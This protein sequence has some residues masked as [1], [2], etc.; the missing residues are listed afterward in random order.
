MLGSLVS[1]VCDVFRCFDLRRSIAAY[2]RL[3]S[4]RQFRGCCNNLSRLKL[5]SLQQE[6][7]SAFNR[8]AFEKHVRGNR[9]VDNSKPPPFYFNLKI[10]GSLSDV[11]DDMWILRNGIDARRSRTYL[12]VCTSLRHGFAV[13]IRKD[14]VVSA[15]AMW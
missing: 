8:D 7:R 5:T 6:E 13:R 11:R 12:H 15:E 4:M 9:G 1:S 10:D 2:L 3:S 14:L